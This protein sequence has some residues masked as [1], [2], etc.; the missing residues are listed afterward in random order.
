M[1]K[2]LM[3]LMLNDL[4]LIEEEIGVD[5]AIAEMFL[6][7]HKTCVNE[8]PSLLLYLSEEIIFSRFLSL[9]SYTSESFS[10][11]VNLILPE[12][13]SLSSAA[14]VCYFLNLCQRLYDL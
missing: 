12:A 7:V 2:L 11:A 5:S 8:I 6:V 3:E 13:E 1:E 10:I 9:K 4:C 14:Y